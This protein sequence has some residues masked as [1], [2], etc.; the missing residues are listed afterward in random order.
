MDEKKFY[1]SK[2]LVTTL[3]IFVVRK[4]SN[5]DNFYYI[6][7]VNQKEEANP[8]QKQKDINKKKFKSLETHTANIVIKFEMDPTK[9]VKFY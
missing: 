8:T 5:Q 2:T 6:N 4:C 3:G 9:I 1:P 7:I